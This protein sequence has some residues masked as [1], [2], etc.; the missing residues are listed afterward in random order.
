MINDEIDKD[1]LNS[2][3]NKIFDLEKRNISSKEYSENKILD[4]IYVIFQNELEKE[5]TNENKIN[6]VKEL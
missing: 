4:K 5:N 2:L 1:I 6:Y 3:E